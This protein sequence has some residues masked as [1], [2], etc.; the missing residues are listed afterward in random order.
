VVV[1]D[2]P[3]VLRRRLEEHRWSPVTAALGTHFKEKS[4]KVGTWGHLLKR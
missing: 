3:H 2:Y 1:E 4:E